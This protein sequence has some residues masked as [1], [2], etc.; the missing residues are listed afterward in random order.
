VRVFLEELVGL[1]ERLGMTRRRRDTPAPPVQPTTGDA[2]CRAMVDSNPL[3][4][5]AVDPDG[6]LTMV[7]Q[8]F[9]LFVKKEKKEL[10]G[11]PLAETRLASFAPGLTD[12]LELV[13]RKNKV[14]SRELEFSA[15]GAGSKVLI[16]LAPLTMGGF[17]MGAHGIVHWIQK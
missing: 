8:S 11:V 12:D 15:A 4:M 3:P 7:N 6:R 2:A 5:F 9:C 17:I 14:T 16:W 10:V 1:M 13:V